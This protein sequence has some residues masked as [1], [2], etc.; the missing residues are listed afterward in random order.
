MAKLVADQVS[1][2]VTLNRYQLA[3]QVANLDFWMAQVRHCLGVVDG[4]GRRFR[5]QQEAQQRHVAE[6]H[7]I[8]FDLDDPCCTQGKPAP[9]RKVPDRDLKRARVALTEATRRLLIRCHRAG[10]LDAAAFRKACE[11]SA[12][13]FDPADLAKR[14]GR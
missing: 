8:E 11:D 5:L 7:T 12:I 14:R 2:F 3:G 13:G 6:F 10:F 1:R 4:Y 9:P